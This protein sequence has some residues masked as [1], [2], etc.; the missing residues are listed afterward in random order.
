MGGIDS[1]FFFRLP[2]PCL[3]SGTSIP[4]PG[5]IIR[6]QSQYQIPASF[7]APHFIPDPYLFFFRARIS[8][9]SA[10]RGRLTRLVVA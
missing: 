5:L 3:H 10:P 4:D 2:E 9:A 8:N 7:S 1:A 6:T